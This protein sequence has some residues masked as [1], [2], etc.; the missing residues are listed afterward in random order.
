M[1]LELA[2]S[3]VAAALIAGMGVWLAIRDHRTTVRRTAPP[4]FDRAD[5]LTLHEESEQNHAT[6]EED[7]PTT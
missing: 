6:T 1:D 7:S 5:T 4:R 3:I 2:V